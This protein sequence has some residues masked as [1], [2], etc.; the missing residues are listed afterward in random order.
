MTYVLDG[1]SHFE[2]AMRAA[3]SIFSPRPALLNQGGQHND[4][5]AG[6]LCGRPHSHTSMMRT[7]S[8]HN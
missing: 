5:A 1:T 8:T 7:P 3:A 2:I 4:C 6:A